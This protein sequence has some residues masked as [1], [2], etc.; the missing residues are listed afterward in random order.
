MDHI[1]NSYLEALM[2]PLEFLFGKPWI[3]PFVL[4]PPMLI[5]AAWLHWDAIRKTGPYIA[6]VRARVIA[7]K[8]ALGQD[9]NPDAE[10]LAFSQNYS[11]VQAAFQAT[12]PGAQVLIEAWRELRE[13]FVDESASTILNTTRPFAFFHKAELRLTQLQF[14]SNIFV[15][16]GLILTFLGLIVALRTAAHGMQGGVAEAQGALTTLLVV[17]AAKFFTSVGGIGASVWLRFAEHGLSHKISVETRS[18]STL[19]ERGLVFIPPQRLAAQQLEELREQT[20]QLK[21]FNQDVAFQLADRI[22][23]GV[24]QAFAPMSASLAILNESM[25]SVTEGIGAGARD[26]IEKVSGDQLRELGAIIGSLGDRLNGISDAVGHSGGEAA[27]QIREAGADFRVAA[28]EIRSAFETLAGQVISVGDKITEQGEHAAHAQGEAL[29]RMLEGMEHAQTRSSEAMSGAVTALQQAAT[30]ASATMQDEIEK[31]IEKGISQTGERFKAVLEES[32]E[33]LRS[34]ATG[35]ARAVSSAADQI[36]RAK[37][38]FARSG[39]SATETASAMEAV[40]GH[41]RTAAQALEA[42]A[43]DFSDCSEPIE[44]AAKSF[45]ESAE[46]MQTAIEAT[47]EAEVNV[48]ADFKA[49]SEGIRETQTSAELAWRDYRARFEGVDKSLE[50]TTEALADSLNNSLGT[51][52][53]FARKFDSELAAAVGKLGASLDSIDTYANSLD[54]FVDDTRRRA[55]AAAA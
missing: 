22:H 12:G 27:L 30:Q 20:A 55:P 13:T 14:W 24:S 33:G 25:I 35:L 51:F 52:S 38:G 6:A 34:A 41:A 49:L 53:E 15:G 29:A 8:S 17:A 43:A 11:D 44:D 23:A 48:L 5:G 40:A 54:E 42:A 50:K 21:Y 2:A 19:L 16:I 3:A 46:R 32:G 28:T 10:R 39:A 26:A 18:L 9:A 31:T 36:D 7:L 1:L 4:L 47:R 45:S 37:E